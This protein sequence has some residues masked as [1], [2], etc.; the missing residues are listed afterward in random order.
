MIEIDNFREITKKDK[1]YLPRTN[2]GLSRT[3]LLIALLGGGVL[4]LILVWWAI[5]LFVLILATLSIFEYFDEDIYDILIIRSK[6]KSKN[7]FYA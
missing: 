5:P 7:I 1:V 2:I 6:M 3:S 4:W